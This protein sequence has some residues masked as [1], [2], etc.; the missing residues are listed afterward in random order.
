MARVCVE[1]RALAEKRL[2]ILMKA[3]RWR[4]SQAIGTLV[5]L[6]HDSQEMRIAHASERQLM[7]WLDARNDAEARR[8]ID[9]LVRAYYVEKVEA[10][11]GALYHIR[12]NK[13][14]VQALDAMDDG[15]RK[16]GE[17][18]S[19]LNKN[20]R[21]DQVKAEKVSA[22]PD[23]ERAAILFSSTL[24]SSSLCSSTLISSEESSSEVAKAPALIK[25]KKANPD[26]K[27]TFDAYS[28][29]YQSR[30]GEPPVKNAT[31]NSQISNFVKRIGADEAPQVAAFYVAHNN[32]F[33]VST[34]HSVGI[35][36]KDAEKLRTE[37]AT[38]MRMLGSKA[39]EVERAQ[40]S[41]DSWDQAAQM[42][43]D[44]REK[45]EAVG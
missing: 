36:L 4:K 28:A 41:S 45:N 26:N 8:I 17:R 27:K 3:M 23:G 35:M 21:I 13:K 19:E 38:G 43:N 5:L 37:W 1:A 22:H 11:G 24:L 18:T 2:E 25:P 29:A 44:R 33:Y 16:G 42:L 20:A 39:R 32:A 6:W 34:M 15:R 7:D 9:A 30:Y 40:H 12:G 31:V 14:H 10:I